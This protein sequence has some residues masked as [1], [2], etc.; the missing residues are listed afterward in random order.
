MASISWL[1]VC[2]S[3]KTASPVRALIREN[4]SLTLQPRWPPSNSQ[5]KLLRLSPAA[6][7]TTCSLSL[8]LG[9]TGPRAPAPS[10]VRAQLAV[11][12]FRR[13]L[14]KGAVGVPPSG[15]WTP[16]PVEEHLAAGGQASWARVKLMAST[17]GASLLVMLWTGSFRHLQL[18]IEG[19][20]TRWSNH[21]NFPICLDL[22]WTSLR[23][24]NS[25]GFFTAQNP[26]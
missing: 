22:G 4:F 17:L 19:L 13:L 23:E 7:R 26:T 12:W 5:A 24:T 3:V 6:T 14:V 9:G 2:P 10:E 18:K 16:S 11:F 15:G 8:S 1:C 25:L 21:T 20:L